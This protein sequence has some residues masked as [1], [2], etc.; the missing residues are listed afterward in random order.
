MKALIRIPFIFLILAISTAHLSSKDNIHF[1][2]AP[3]FEGEQSFN[4]SDWLTQVDAFY[5]YGNTSRGRNTHGNTVSLLDIYDNHNLL[6]LTANVAQPTNLNAS[7]KTIIDN[8]DTKRTAFE[9]DT[10]ALKASRSNF[11]LVEFTGKFE[12]HDFAFTYKQNLIKNIFLELNMPLRHMQI[13]NISYI[14]HSTT[15]SGGNKKYTDQDP[16]WIDFI[17]KTTFDDILKAYGLT[18]YKSGF[19]KVAIGDISIMAGYQ[20]HFVN[21]SDLFEYLDL[22]IKAGVIIP[23][24]ALRN[25]S[26]PFSLPV[27]YNGHWGFP[28]SLDALFWL[29]EDICFGLYGG[30]IFF[31]NKTYGNYPVKTDEHQNGFIKLQRATVTEKGANIIDLGTYLKL[32]HFFKGLSAQVGYSFNYRAAQTLT[33][34]SYLIKNDNTLKD[35]Y[36]HVLHAQASYDLGVHGYFKNRRWQ[37]RFGIFYDYPIT[38]KRIFNTAMLGGT[39]GC[40]FEWRF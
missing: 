10:S 1:Y 22:A 26:N 12:V 29:S 30:A 16:D 35:W 20:H 39:I 25:F 19:S 24:G 27:G 23:T 32:D 11:G 38:G 34:A 31:I 7:L 40:D 21:Q 2:K 8:L 37:P 17:N 15:Y 18:G 5:A 6:Y 4:S 36:M 28:I 14:D 3:H 13:K 9:A 33:S